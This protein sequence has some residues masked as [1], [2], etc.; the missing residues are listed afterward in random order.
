MRDI[1]SS[2]RIVYIWLGKGNAKTD[3]AMD[4]LAKGGLPFR[5]STA[6]K[7]RD[8][9]PTGNA[10]CWKLAWYIYSRT[11]TSRRRPHYDGLMDVFDREW[12]RR[13]WTMQEVLL[14]HKPVLMCGNKTASWKG[15]VYSLE[16]FQFLS[17]KPAFITFPPKQQQW[18]R[19][20]NL[21]HALILQGDLGGTAGITSDGI[22]S[23]QS[24]IQTHRHTIE[25]A[26]RRFVFI[27]LLIAFLAVSLF[28]GG[29]LVFFF[30]LFQ[31]GRANATILIMTPAVPYLLLLA[32]VSGNQH[33][34]RCRPFSTTENIFFQIWER[35]STD[36]KDR[37][38]GVQAL[39]GKE[40]ENR[41][42]CHRSIS[43]TRVYRRL[44]LAL[45]RWTQSLD[46]LLWIG[47][48]KEDPSWVVDWAPEARSWVLL[49][50][51]HT[52]TWWNRWDLTSEFIY[53][54][55]KG[56]T[57]D[58]ESNWKTDGYKT[59]LVVYGKMIGELC[60]RS[61][62][63]PEAPPGFQSAVAEDLSLSVMD[64]RKAIE[65]MEVSQ[66]TQIMDQL[67]TIT[68]SYG[69]GDKDN[70]KF[71][72]KWI[73]SIYGSI[74]KGPE[75]GIQ[76]LNGKNPLRLSKFLRWI[77]GPNPACGF[78]YEMVKYMA[79]NQRVLVRSTGVYSGFGI[80]CTCSRVGDKVAL[81]SGVSMPLI[82]RKHERGYVVV[83]PA[84]FGGVMNGEFWKDN[85]KD[86]LEELVLA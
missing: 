43:Q 47:C 35:Q 38:Y 56:A 20:W 81:I 2:A 19:L 18:W 73:Q 86:A 50:Y 60:W 67:S 36:C 80:S 71:R 53:G 7:G 57:P 24:E 32:K 16:L 48:D 37:Y 31:H 11:I 25:R 3:A 30:A 15:V 22:S 65:G 66:I 39:I 10:V 13:I 68:V 51:Y 52:S 4:Y 12:I 14:A 69:P 27:F 42:T 5:I 70:I 17:K 75:W 29:G 40:E 58:S 82:L 59:K 26:W 79:E 74:E 8:D 28:L 83:G 21:Q 6:K 9:I 34:T 33:A 61:E 72:K 85:G 63:P 46:I 77:M 49:L 84:F 44:S 76:Q 41:L 54:R 23:L 45:L 78:H 1:Y 62:R 64:F 55:L